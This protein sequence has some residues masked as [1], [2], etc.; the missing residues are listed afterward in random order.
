ML[1]WIGI[2]VAGLG[3]ALY[4][5]SYVLL[6]TRAQRLMNRNPAKLRDVIESGEAREYGEGA[7]DLFRRAMEYQLENQVRPVPLVRPGIALFVGGLL[8]AVAGYF[9]G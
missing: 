9:M 2:A 1:Y 7:E 6:Q 4:V 8:L 5:L 3:L